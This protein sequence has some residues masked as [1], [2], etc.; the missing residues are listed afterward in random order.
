MESTRKCGSFRRLR[1][2]PETVGVLKGGR[3]RGP[4]FTMEVMMMKKKD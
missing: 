4:L 1:G 3:G 2:G